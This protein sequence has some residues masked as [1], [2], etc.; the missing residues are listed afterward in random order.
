LPSAKKLG[1]GG[2]VCFLG[3]KEPGK[4]RKKLVL[5]I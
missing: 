5:Q 1:L 4:T 2:K 3:E